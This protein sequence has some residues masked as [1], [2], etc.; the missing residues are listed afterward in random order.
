[1]EL[2]DLKTTWQSVKPG[3]KNIGCS[4]QISDCLS[5]KKDVKSRLLIKMFLEVLFTFVCLI[6]M[7]TSHLW[8]PTKLSVIWLGAFCSVIVVAIVCGI[9]LYSAI[10]HIN[11]WDDTNA[12]ILTAIVKVKKRYRRIE[13]AISI[14][15]LAL[16]IWLSMTPPF[17]NTLDMYIVWGLTA[18][19]FGLEYL[20]YRGN[21]RQL[22]ILANWDECKIINH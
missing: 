16:L 11:I 2:E 6:L 13:L 7:A 18:I 9:I 12:G 19:C 14:M 1:M 8:S 4:A 22:N 3:I 10:R 21:I 20:W 17:L 15:I 5:R